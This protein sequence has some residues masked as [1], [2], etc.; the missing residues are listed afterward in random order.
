[1]TNE[2]TQYQEE[3]LLNR[4]RVSAARILAPPPQL[5]LDEWS[6][7]YLYLSAEASA[8]PGKF[9]FDRA[10]FQREVF[11]TLSDNSIRKV[12][13]M[14]ASQTLKTQAVLAYLGYIVH[15]DPGPILIVQP[16]NKM[17][18]TFSKDRV[19]TMLRDVPQL[20]GRIADKR[21]RDGG[22]TA[23]HKT[24]TG[25][26]MTIATA[27][28]PSDL[29]A[30]PIRFLF[31]DE[32]D[33]YGPTTEGDPINIASARTTTF[34]NHKH[35]LVSSPGDED[36]SR[37]NAE[38]ENS[39]KRVYYVPCHECGE[40]QVLEWK[41]VKWE[42]DKPETAA[43]HCANCETAWS[44]Q[45]RNL[46]IAK[47]RWVASNP[48]K[49]TAGFWVS[50]LYSSFKTIPDLAKEFLEAKT[51]PEQLKTFVNTRLAQTWKNA[52]VTIGDI[53][54][55]NR[56]ENY[57]TESIPDGVLLITA[58]IDVQD[59][60]LE[61]EIVGWG[62]GDESWSLE[63]ITIMGN[64][65][66]PAP[67]TQLEQVLDKK[68]KREDGLP[69]I[70]NAAAIDTG[71]SA[72]QD[73]NNWVAKQKRNVL[74]IKGFAGAGKAIFPKKYGH[75]R[76]GGRFY[77]VG[78]DTAKER[79]YTH[80]QIKEPGPGY[81]H[82]PSGYNEVYFEGLTSERYQIKYKK[83]HPYKVWEKKN[84]VRNEPLDCRVYATAARMSFNTLDLTR[85]REALKK[86]LEKLGTTE[87]KPDDDIKPTPVT[88]APKARRVPKTGYVSNLF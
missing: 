57:T 52:S 46:N 68:Y 8:L 6:E 56:L 11:R 53:P 32:T 16:N 28:S 66:S 69:M 4:L 27:G 33:R 55:L 25:G 41:Q 20:K 59:N 61:M 78:V 71:G 65:T 58:G 17:A 18:H 86:K 83:G 60:R 22:N 82:F 80:L 51:D 38:Y 1:M 72:T 34:W 36:I 23:L 84:A 42:K 45:Q 35:V 63:Y 37:I 88:T 77:A 31:F 50:A 3:A 67:W 2:V 44:D 70:I 47:G 48:T 85:R 76:K 49:T 29:A 7:Q 12:V 73:V 74:P 43:Y 40:E 9:R 39:D 21:K 75:Y 87:E 30:R 79:I 10:P 81:C 54:F 64:P 62:I 24:F 13:I 15:L 19:D 5:H 26:A 14:A